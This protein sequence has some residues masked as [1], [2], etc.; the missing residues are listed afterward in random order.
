MLNYNRHRCVDCHFFIRRSRPGGQEMTSMVSRDERAGSRIGDF[1]WANRQWALSCYFG[2]WDEGV[3][4]VSD[5]WQTIVKEERGDSCFFRRY[6]PG[7]LLPAAKLLQ[8]REMAAREARGDRR[9]TLCALVVAVIAIVAQVR[10]SVITG[11]A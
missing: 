9:L 11:T 1:S 2:V 5:Y 4:P 3:A 6:H 7:M 8:E 10:T